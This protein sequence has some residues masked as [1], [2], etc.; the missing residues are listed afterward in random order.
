[1]KYIHE[2]KLTDVTPFGEMFNHCS[3]LWNK[4]QDESLSEEE[5]KEA[6]DEW[7]AKRQAL[8]MGYYNF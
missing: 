2:I 1:M 6:S 3:D 4:S 8:E 7:L 5:K